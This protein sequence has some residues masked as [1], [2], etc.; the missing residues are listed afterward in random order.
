MESDKYKRRMGKKE[1]KGKSEEKK[2][3]SEV[4]PHRR[5]PPGQLHSGAG[6]RTPHHLQ[7]DGR[8]LRNMFADCQN[9]LKIKSY[10]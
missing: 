10:S 7:P 2:S 4:A 3:K 1:E 9:H 8:I 5:P 6:R